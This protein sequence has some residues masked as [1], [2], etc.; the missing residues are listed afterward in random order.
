MRR[1]FSFSAILNFRCLCRQESPMPSRIDDL[2][3]R[4]SQL[5]AEIEKE[6]NQVQARWHYSITAGRV[7]FEREVE[8]AHKRLKQSLLKFLS[9]SDPLSIITAPVIYSLIVPIAMLDLWVTIYQNICFR[10]YKIPRVR[11]RV[12]IVMDRQHL[13]YLNT[14]E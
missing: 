12:Y 10:A 11:R 14:F 13:A 7:R 9:E 4:L 3:A 6:L 5:E 2:L 8:R 1:V